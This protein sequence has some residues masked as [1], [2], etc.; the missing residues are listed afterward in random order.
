MSS[1]ARPTP[2]SS[3]PSASSPSSGTRTST[4]IPRPRS[5][6]RRSTRRTRSSPIRSGAS[7]TTC[8]AAPGSMAAA[9]APAF[10]RRV[11]RLQRHLRCL[12]RRRG[13]PTRRGAAARSPA[14]TSATT[15]GSRSRR[16]SAAPRRRSSSGSSAAARRAAAAAPSPAPS[17]S[18]CPQC[19]GRGEVRSVR[20]TMLGQMVNVSACPRCQGEGKI[21][22]TPCETCQGDGRTER[23][24]TPAGHDPGRASTRATR[25][26][27]RT[28]A[29]SGRAAGPPAACTWRSTSA[30]HPTLKREGTELYY[31]ADVSIAQAALGT[32][33]HGAD[34]RGRRGGRDQGRHA[35]RYR[36]PAARQGRSAPAPQRLAR[37]PPRAR[38][39]RR[40]DQALEAPARAARGV[41]RGVRRG[42]RR[43]AAG[44]STR[45]ATRW[46]TGLRPTRARPSPGRRLAG[47]L[48]RGGRRGG[49]GR[50]RDPRPGGARRDQPSSRRSS[51][52]TR[53]WARASTRP[54]RRSSAAYV[55]AREPRPRPRPPR[56]GRRGARPSPGVRPAADRRAADAGRPRGRLGRGV[57][58]ALPGAAG[59]SAARHPADVAAASTAR[60]TMW[61]SP[62]IRAW[63][64]ARACTRRRGCVSAALEA[65]ADRGRL[66]GARVLDVGC[67]SGI[68]AHR[69]ASGSAPP[70]AL[71]VDTDPIAIE[72]TAANARRN[73]LAPPR[74][75]RAMGSLPSGEPAVRRRPRE[76][77]R[78]AARAARAGARATSSR[79]AG[80]LLA[81]GIFIDREAEVRAAFEAVG[82]ARRRARSAEGDWVALEAAV[83]AGS[84]TAPDPTIAPMPDLL[85]VPARHAYRARHLACSCPRSCC[86]SPC[87][88]G[89]RRSNPTAPS[90]GASSGRR[91]TARWSSALG[92]AMTGLG[93]VGMLGSTLLEQPWLLVALAI[94][95]ANLALAFFIQRPNLRR[96][97]GVRPRPTTGPGRSARSASATCRTSWPGSSG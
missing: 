54:G 39:R 35:A 56:R 82:L 17:R 7:A 57:E 84:S 44:S 31:E 95:F 37:R 40:P 43:P 6:S 1:A 25:S 63:R 22:E 93:L 8:S 14:R 65:L 87:A 5:A 16:P 21:I 80:T 75:A 64:S 79:P 71:G 28:R 26:G 38:R 60:P 53:G 34:G 12:L 13:R 49:R 81:S 18:T 97:V 88:H 48:G 59:R 76:P 33:H 46:L 72:A 10:E 83:R 51:S 85:P 36:D 47:A 50:Q 11:R 61:C 69:R 66:D 23:K 73:R 19:D 55:P 86:R 9:A 89:A 45:S 70:S 92:L 24:R 74:S 41:R 90:S 20:Q 68:L 96:L 91:R 4:P 29:R 67:G 62:S 52:S 77:H 27:S 42:R 15:C 78:G 58:G 30:P 3:A 94:Y 2:R 32:T